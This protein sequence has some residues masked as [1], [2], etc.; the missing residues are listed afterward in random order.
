MGELQ[1]R[2]GLYDIG[3]CVTGLCQSWPMEWWAEVAE[4][5]Q[6]HLPWLADVLDRI[7]ALFFWFPDFAQSPGFAGV[8]AVIA[9]WIAYSAARK[10]ARESQRWN[11]AETALTMTLSA[12]SSV[13]KAGL[14]LLNVSLGHTKDSAEREY[15]AAALEWFVRDLKPKHDSAE[16]G[17]ESVHVTGSESESGSAADASPHEETSPRTSRSRLAYAI[18]RFFKRSGR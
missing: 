18:D 1:L 17:S 10:N 9:A 13:R 4:W 6:M 5:V 15:I 14:Q 12:D 11:R 16:G 7:F 3:V 8:L 2:R